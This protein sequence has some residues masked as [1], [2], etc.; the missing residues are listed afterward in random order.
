MRITSL[1]YSLGNLRE[2]LFW[3]SKI[4][5]EKMEV[6]NLTVYLLVIVFLTVSGMPIYS[7][8]ESKADAKALFEQKCCTCHSIEISKSKKKTSNEWESTVIRMK[9]VN[10]APITNDEAKDIIDYLS[11]HY[12][13]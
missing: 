4:K 10:G 13:K 2:G 11:K 12:G 6:K 7:A 1:N 5:K 3:V 9:D 8:E